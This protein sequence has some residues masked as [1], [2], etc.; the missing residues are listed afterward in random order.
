MKLFFFT[1]FIF[2]LLLTLG[3]AHQEKYT[4]PDIQT[5]GPL[6]YLSDNLNEKKQ[7]GWCIDTEGKGFNNIL[8]S[9]SCKPEGADTQFSYAPKTKNVKSVTFSNKCMSLNN[10][11]H[12]THPFGL[13]D[14]DSSNIKQKFIYNKKTKEITSVYKPGTCVVVAKKIIE[15]GPYQSRDLLI[16]NCSEV[17]KTYKQWTIKN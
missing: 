13:V 2:S 3:C 8:Q 16:K 5:K 15:A 14:C 17:E 11:E 7:L 6:I 10:S 1:T 4:A 12:T 9:H